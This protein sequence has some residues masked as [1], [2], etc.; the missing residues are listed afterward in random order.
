VFFGFILLFDE[1]SETSCVSCSISF[2]FFS[3]KETLHWDDA[4]W[5]VLHAVVAERS[6]M[7]RSATSEDCAEAVIA[8]LRN[9][10][11]TGDIAVIDGGLTLG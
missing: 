6:P 2:P 9:T 10:Y 7:G 3:G 5:D 1:V 11:Q 4:A 8:I